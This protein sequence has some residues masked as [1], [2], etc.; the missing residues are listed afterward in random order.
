MGTWSHFPGTEVKKK[1]KTISQLNSRQL[2]CSSKSFAKVFSDEINILLM[3]RA[4]SGE[5]DG[6]FGLH[7][8][9]RAWL[10]SLEL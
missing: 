6:D 9:L 4:L 7:G 3:K 10:P 1:N 8:D 2:C 5:S